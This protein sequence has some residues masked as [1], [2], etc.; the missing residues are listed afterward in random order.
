MSLLTTEKVNLSTQIKNQSGLTKMY[1]EIRKWLEKIKNFKKWKNS[2][3][4]NYKKKD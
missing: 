3:K 2:L 4:I 1:K